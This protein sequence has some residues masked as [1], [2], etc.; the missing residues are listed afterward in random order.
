[1]LSKIED[2]NYKC[3]EERKG[4]ASRD[5]LMVGMNPGSDQT[6]AVQAFRQTLKLLPIQP[7]VHH[8]YCIY[9]F[10]YTF[11]CNILDGL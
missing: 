6:L 5:E 2:K 11:P 3:G 1:M 8:I 7:P 9:T 4:E 10:Q